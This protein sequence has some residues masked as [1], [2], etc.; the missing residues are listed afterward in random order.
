MGKFHRERR[1]STRVRGL[2]LNLL[3]R[4]GLTNAQLVRYGLRKYYE[5]HPYSNEH[6]I[7]TE[8]AFLKDKIEECELQIESYS[9]AIQKKINELHE[10][11]QSKEDAIYNYVVK[12]IWDEYLEF[13]DNESLSPEFRSDLKNFYSY[14]NDGISIIAMKVH[15]T[16]DDIIKIFEDYLEFKFGGEN[17]LDDELVTMDESVV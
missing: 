11:R 10:V 13:L 15:K 1:V 16:K 8:V 6:M 2:E 9:L 7:L 17:I 14:C 5:D 4:S 3:E 12:N